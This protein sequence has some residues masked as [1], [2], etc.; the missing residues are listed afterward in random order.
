MKLST[1][2][3]ANTFYGGRMR[4]APLTWM[5]NDEIEILK[6]E[7]KQN[8]RDPWKITTLRFESLRFG[9]RCGVGDIESRSGT[10][11]VRRL[12]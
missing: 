2:R 12:I 3:R 6:T 8:D 9:C 7:K 5:T 4:C 1:D 10:N 11:L